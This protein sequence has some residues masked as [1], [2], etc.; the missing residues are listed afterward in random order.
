MHHGLTSATIN[1]SDRTPYI[2]HGYKKPNFSTEASLYA[3]FVGDGIAAEAFSLC[4]HY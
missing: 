4:F 1:N 3:A 2:E